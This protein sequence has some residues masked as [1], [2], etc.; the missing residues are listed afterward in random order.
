MKM[1]GEPKQRPGV[2]P[3]YRMFFLNAVLSQRVFSLL[4]R[5]MLYAHFSVEAKNIIQGQGSYICLQVAL[6]LY[7]PY[8]YAIFLCLGFP[9]PATW[10]SQGMTAFKG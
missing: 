5:V 9:L 10:R 7:S 4:F 1:K 6:L 2:I 3:K 8:F